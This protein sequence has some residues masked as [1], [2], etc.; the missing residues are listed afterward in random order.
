VEPTTQ[1]A[2]TSAYYLSVI[3]R[4]RRIVIACALIGALVGTLYVLTRPG[5]YASTASVVIRPVTADPLG[6]STQQTISPV[7]EQS[8]M[9]STVVAQRA[10]DILED[11]ADAEDLLKH[12]T[13]SNPTDTSVLSATYK[14]S[15][16]EGARDGAQAFADAY[17]EY[18]QGQ[19][20]GIK[21]RQLASIDAELTPLHDNVAEAQTAVAAVAPGTQA[22]FNAQQ[23]VDRLQARVIEAESQRSQIDAVDTTPGE[24]IKPARLPTGTSGV[25]TALTVVAA[26]VLGAMIGIVAALVRQ[27]T[28][29]HMRARPDFVEI[30][31][32]PPLGE[33]RQDG[34]R[35]R[36]ALASRNMS[37][38]RHL[39]VR[40]WPSR[41]VKL[42]KVLVA[43]VENPRTTA[44]VVEGLAQSLA[45][46][47]WRV[48]VVWP[49]LPGSGFD[50]SALE[51]VDGVRLMPWS[52]VDGYSSDSIDPTSLINTLEDATDLDDVVL[53]AAQPIASTTELPELYSLVDG[54]LVTVDPSAVRTDTLQTALDEVK[55][56]GGEVA[57]VVVTPVPARW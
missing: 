53:L 3:R 55:T 24:V 13:V 21:E 49:D 2:L 43:D 51:N 7:T 36:G 40:L 52:S 20:D 9:A 54:V 45:N 32:E 19:Y 30:F 28:D 47:H 41:P 33:I 38:F 8:V 48:L 25:P 37:D 11:G 42:Q 5:G 34:G 12:L 39:R 17:L 15:T 26:T 18:R 57:G 29:S 50:T 10:A 35:R 14:A 22:F 46:A 4:R 23:Q 31:D 56:M 16:P 6:D 1:H 27:R 44:A